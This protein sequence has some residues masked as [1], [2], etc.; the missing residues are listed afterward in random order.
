MPQ[1]FGYT[2]TVHSVV[3]KHTRHC[4]PERMRVD[5]GQVVTL[6][7]LSEPFADAVGVHRAAVIL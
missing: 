7:E 6:A 5:M 2:H 1:P 4:V 3:I